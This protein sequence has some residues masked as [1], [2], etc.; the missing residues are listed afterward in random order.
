[1]EKLCEAIQNVNTEAYAT[2]CAE[3]DNITPLDPWKTSLLLKGRSHIDIDDDNNAN[4]GDEVASEGGH[5]D[6]LL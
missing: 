2:A 6:D 1:M 3:F 4:E 5:D